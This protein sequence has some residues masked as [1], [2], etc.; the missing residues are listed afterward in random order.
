MLFE[1][2]KCW[3][4]KVFIGDKD[5]LCLRRFGEMVSVIITFLGLLAFGDEYVFEGFNVVFCWVF[6][7]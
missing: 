2:G 3:L 4:F 6:P 5:V 1:K 7:T